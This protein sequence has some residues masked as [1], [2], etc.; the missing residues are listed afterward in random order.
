[1]T[2]ANIT[3]NNNATVTIE[4]ELPH[5]A[6]KKHRAASLKHLGS[7]VKIDGFR[8]G[9]IPENI[10]IDRIGEYTLLQEMAERA[11]SEH[12]P[13]LLV[14]HKIDAIGRPDIS[15]TKLAAGNPLGFK[16]T[17]AVMPVV[18]L[19]DY[20]TLAKDA[21]KKIGNEPDLVTEEDIDKVV[22]QLLAEKQ[23]AESEKTNPPAGGQKTEN[24]EELTKMTDDVAKTF[25]PFENVQQLR[26]KIREGMEADKKRQ[27]IEKKRVEIMEVIMNETK[28]VIPDVLIDAELNKLMAQISHDVEHMGM[29]HEDYLK[30]IGK[31]DEDLR[32]EFR[33]DAEKRAKS[34]LVLNAI[35]S[36]EN[37]KPDQKEL[38]HEVEHLLSHHM[39]KGASV[40]ERERQSATIYVETL[41]TN[42]KVLEFLEKQG[43]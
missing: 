9:H 34:Q 25:G 20:A 31:T 16:I 10:L 14:E 8:E 28:V 38:D 30:A 5:E 11:L 24:K 23:K 4:G 3:T 19:P 41:M 40:G 27:H 36:K 33:P 26:A 17:T 12:Y 43:M 13:L 35:A 37:I 29:K 32:K 7:K 42:Q 1:M 2:K 15:V 39:P 21:A 6:L 22:G 18:E